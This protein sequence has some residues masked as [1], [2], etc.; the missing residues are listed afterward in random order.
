MLTDS[1]KLASRLRSAAA[2]GRGLTSRGLASDRVAGTLA[3]LCGV[4]L[5]LVYALP[6]GA[7]DHVRFEEYGLVIW[8]TLA[9]GCAVGVLPR[10]RPS[11]WV[12]AWLAMML[13]YT[14]WT[15]LSLTWTASAER[16]TIEITRTLDYLGLATIIG[17]SVDRRTW[18]P[19]AAGLGF[20]AL[21]VCV[22][23]VAGRLDPGALPSDGIGGADL[24]RLSYP[25][26]YWNAV[27]A[28]SAMAGV[29]GL[30]FAAHDTSALRR[31]LALALVPW[32]CVAEYLS[33]SRGGVAGI[34]IGV[35]V[36]LLLSRQRMTAVLS[37]VVAGGGAAVAILV[38]RAHREIADGTGAAGAGAVLTALL[39]ASVIA[40]GAAITLSLCGVDRQRLP[41]PL[42]RAVA[43]VATLVFLAAAVGF[44]PHLASRGWHSFSHPATV[45]P[46]TNPSS[47]LL[48]LS[49]TR[50][51]VWKAAL[52]AFDAHPINGTGAG[53]FQ[54][55]WNQHGTTY[56][57]DQDAHSV[58]LQNLAELGAPG[59]GLIIAV[60]IGGLAI[61][62]LVRQKTRRG[63]SAGVA[64]ACLAA[65]VVFLTQASVD[66]MWESTAVTVLALAGV[67]VL[68]VRLSQPRT[69]V[70]WPWRLAFTLLAISAAGAQVPS[71]LSTVDVNKSQAAERA[72]NG[73]AALA[74][75]NDAVAIEPWGASNYE[76]RALVDEAG[77]R[78]VAAAANERRAIDHEP[79]NFTHWLIMSRIQTE[80]GR[81]AAAVSDYGRAH[82]LRPLA[83]VFVV[84]PYL[85]R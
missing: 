33:Y 75:A 81:Y 29:I 7:Y 56:E 40:A 21:V 43:V 14:A 83:T 12:I 6:G 13:A 9:L 57:F 31:A 76:Q 68:G 10:V 67:S 2:L 17:V 38:V 1:R 23:A 64:A 45:A 73:S 34:T 53:T 18:R 3:F 48:N 60:L 62:V 70:R 36:L 50:Y 52:A 49:G 47:R 85:R 74:W 16:T 35:I 54:F 19:A 37:A 63:A 65:F 71:L 11:R 20:G 42:V 22:L 27:G 58:W 69:P 26:G 66:W 51:A 82:K 80:R 30:G 4:G 15:A 32:A 25:F 24:S 39:A 5:V 77:D 59:L 44:G 41:R 61:A 72:G 79:T 78:L 46:S 84:A 55:W 28:W 8:W